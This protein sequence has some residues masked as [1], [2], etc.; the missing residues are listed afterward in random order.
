MIEAKL[1]SLDIKPGIPFT[2]DQIRQIEAK[3]GGSLPDAYRWMLATYGGI[4]FRSACYM[5]PKVGG[6]VQL[7]WFFDY[8][9][10]SNALRDYAETIPVSMIA[11]GDDS[12]GNVYCLGITGDDQN[13]V[14]FHDHGI[15]WHTD[16][17][18]Y[19]ERG[20]PVPSSLRYQ[21]VYMIG[22]SFVGFIQGLFFKE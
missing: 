7:G 17:E 2:V 6:P 14:F 20:E 3:L 4:F 11:I 19:I 21:T 22:E 16:A 18:E 12:G 5:D 13:K 10:L 9:D 1:K 8:D 15:G